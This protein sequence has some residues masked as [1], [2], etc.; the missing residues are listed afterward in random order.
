MPPLTAGLR[1]AKGEYVV[2]FAT[3]DIL[4]PQRIEKQVGLFET[5]DAT[6]GVMFTDA[7]YIDGHGR[8]FRKHYEYLFA[9]GLLDHIPQGD[10]YTQRAAAL[11]YMLADHDGA[12]CRIGRAERL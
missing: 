9:K 1:L 5:L 4:L 10:V 7:E 11:L 12:A 6:Y 8:P 2:D 3:D